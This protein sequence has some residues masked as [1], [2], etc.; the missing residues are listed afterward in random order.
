M[1]RGGLEELVMLEKGVIHKQDI[2]FEKN[3]IFNKR[4][5]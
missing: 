1:W 4:K 5:I 3:S 2:L